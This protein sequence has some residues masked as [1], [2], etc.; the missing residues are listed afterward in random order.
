LQR[1][2]PAARRNLEPIRKQ[3]SR[4]LEGR[5]GDLLE[6][7]SGTG[8]HAAGIA[9]SLPDLTWHPSDPDPLQRASI[10]AH[11]DAVGTPNLRPA[12]DLDAAGDW[13]PDL[14][15]P[16]AAIFCANLLHISPPEVT[17]GVFRNAGR[18]LA[19]GGL[20]ILY[21]PFAHDGVLEGAGNLAFDA[22]LRARDPAWGIRDLADLVPLA[23]RA[24]LEWLECIG[25]PA[26]NQINVFGRTATQGRA[27][28]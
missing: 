3:L 13:S 15:G 22:N 4:L 23:E 20:L 12:R 11:R 5:R 9:P 14:P 21:G 2:A 1:F 24:G 6:L 19:P 7:A 8:E 27:S 17:E 28:T 18:H 16:L 26:D 25:M 10:D